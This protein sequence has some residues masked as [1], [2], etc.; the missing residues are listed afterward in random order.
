MQHQQIN[1][2]LIYAYI[3]L[4]SYYMFRRCFL[5]S[6]GSWYQHLFKIYSNKI[7]HNKYINAMILMV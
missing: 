3:V 1:Y 5:I 6:W 2:S 7:G 4:H